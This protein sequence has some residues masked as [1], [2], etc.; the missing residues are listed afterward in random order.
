MTRQLTVGQALSRL[1]A[2]WKQHGEVYPGASDDVATVEQ[3]ITQ[4]EKEASFGDIDDDE[5]NDD[6]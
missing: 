2:H 6:E 5:T 4:A 1:L 3:A